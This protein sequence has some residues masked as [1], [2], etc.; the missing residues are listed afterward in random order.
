MANTFEI[1]EFG[2]LLYG[3]KDAE[4]ELNLKISVYDI[5]KSE[6]ETIFGQEPL[7][8]A[9]ADQLAGY[10]FDLENA[11]NQYEITA[12]QLLLYVS[13]SNI[14]LEL[15]FKS[16]SGLGRRSIIP[17]LSLVSGQEGAVGSLFGI[18]VSNADRLED[19][20]KQGKLF[21]VAGDAGKTEDYLSLGNN[22]CI[23][24]EITSLIFSYRTGMTGITPEHAHSVKTKVGET[25]NMRSNV[26][27]Q[28]RYVWE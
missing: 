24:K 5:V 4:R 9:L 27:L 21:S 22:I 1:N 11:R 20:V 12:R 19:L 13:N 25:L 28:Y 6:L 14:E 17:R 23:G 10:A 7:N 8:E 16:A 3:L 26:T 15:A 2:G 18:L